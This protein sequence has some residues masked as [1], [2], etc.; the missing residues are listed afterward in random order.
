MSAI[1][2]ISS[3]S[4]AKFKSRFT[5]LYPDHSADEL[6]QKLCKVLEEN[7]ITAKVS[8]VG[9]DQRS[10]LLI[11]YAD[12]VQKDGETPLR[13]LKNFLDKEMAGTLDSVHL[14]PFCPWTSDDGFSVADYDA[15]DPAVGG[16]GGRSF[17]CREVQLDVRPCSKSLLC[18]SSLVQGLSGRERVRRKLF[19]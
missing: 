13:T 1:V 19:Y 4:K 11:T 12:N 3:E 7:P 5:F 8:N 10:N 16:W 17:D 14:L 6:V 9:F 18:L 2:S 15:V